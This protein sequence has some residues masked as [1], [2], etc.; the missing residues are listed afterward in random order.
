MTNFP[1]AVIMLDIDH[2]KLFNDRYGHVAGDACLKRIAA[3]VSAELRSVEELAVRYGGEE[4]LVLLPKTEAS[5]AIRMAERIRRSVEALAIPHEAIGAHGI[6]TM[7]CGTAAAPVSMI[8]A[9]EL[10]AGADAA[11]YAAKRNGRN[12][13]WPPLLRDKGGTD[14]QSGAKVISLP[15]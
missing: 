8:S 13:V 10:I 2:F 9:S 3:S 11:L 14:P 5:S 6:V 4:L 12:Q 15:R 7:S 1:V